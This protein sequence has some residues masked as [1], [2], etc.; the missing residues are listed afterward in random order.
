MFKT[1]STIL[2]NSFKGNHPTIPLGR[3]A[4]VSYKQRENRAMR[5]SNDHCGVCTKLK[6]IDLDWILD[7][8]DIKETM[9]QLADNGRYRC[10]LCGSMYHTTK[11]CTNKINS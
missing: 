4:P 7:E 9:K 11:E 8:E 2:L 1:L 10:N 5:S 6:L 3:W